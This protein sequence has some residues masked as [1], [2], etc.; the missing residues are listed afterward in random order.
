MYR[1]HHHRS[2]MRS[3]KNHYALGGLVNR[4]EM[5]PHVSSFLNSHGD[6]VITNLQIGREPV[7][8]TV[9]KVMDTISLG[10]LNKIR[11]K[12]NIDKFYHLYLVINNKYILEKN[13]TVTIRNGSPSKDSQ[14]IQVPLRR[15]LTIRQ[16]IENGIKR[17]GNHDYFTYGAFS[18]RN[19][20]GFVTGNLQGNGIIVP[21]AFV[22]QPIDKIVEN[23]PSYLP[24][25]SNLITDTASILDLLRQ[26][27]GLH[28]GGIVE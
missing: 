18:N 14:V 5:P 21:S 2:L 12:L 26:K 20:Q 6:E 24:K 23:T 28:D 9:M 13:Q 11:S 15:E 4:E 22:N 7:N 8:S 3:H 16:F 17:M 10:A 27:I 1:K 25:V 19:C